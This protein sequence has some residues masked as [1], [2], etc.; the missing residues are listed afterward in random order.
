[1]ILTSNYTPPND[2]S[3]NRRFISVHFPEEEKKANEE[4]EEFKKKF[5]ENKKS[6]SVLGDFCVR[7]IIDNPS[8]LT[9]KRWI[10]IAKDI[11]GHFYEFAKVP[12]PE[13]IDLFEEQR[14]SIDEITEKTL[15][16]LRA[17][18]IDT[19]NDEWARHKKFDDSETD[20]DIFSKF[21]FC[22]EKRLIPFLSKTKDN[23]LIITHDIMTQLKE[24]H[25]IENITT[26]K[27]IGYQ[28]GFKYA[29]KAVYGKKM[30][31]LEGEIKDFNKFIDADMYGGSPLFDS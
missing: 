15:F 12:L 7:H 11:L 23:T 5:N 1:M 24:K 10:D 4:Q 9:N 25:S 3:F 2:G 8:M 19:I 26:L 17:F 31:V 29:N 28:I 6:L 27:D 14:D 21:D 30:R 20:P 22:L 13:W 18:F 16:E